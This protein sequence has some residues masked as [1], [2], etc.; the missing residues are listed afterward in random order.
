MSYPGYRVHRL[1]R[2]RT[3]IILLF[4][5]LLSTVYMPTSSAASA[6][7]AAG[8]Q[9]QPM[10]INDN[11]V[12]FPG[13]LAPYTQSGKLMV[14]IRPFT[15]ALGAQLVYNAQTKSVSVS[16]LGR[17]VNNIRPG[18]TTAEAADGTAFSLEAAPVLRDG[19]LFVPMS[20]V[21][22]ALKSIRWENMLN[23]IDRPILVVQGRQGFTL[24]Q[25]G[26][27]LKVTPFTGL[28]GENYNP[29]YP[30]VLTQEPSGKGYRLNLSVIN[31]SGFIIPKG[32]AALELIAVDSQGQATIRKIPG[33]AGQTA[34]AAAL[35]FTVNIPSA[36][37]YV[38]YNSRTADLGH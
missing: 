21:L 27:W 4:A 13:K 17:I 11:Y 36:A 28:A 18:Q 8:K 26:P 33:P 35:A 34:K 25:T 19:V 14:P 32:S 12:L 30:T 16:L 31:T 22:G 10:L 6:T 3:F 38:I 7:P 1:G 5:S 29:L 24:P 9:I 2:I 37:E 23:T 15:K 20:P